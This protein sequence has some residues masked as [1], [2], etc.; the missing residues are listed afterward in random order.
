MERLTDDEFPKVSHQLQSPNLFVNPSF[1]YIEYNKDAMLSSVNEKKNDRWI[2]TNENHIIEFDSAIKTK[3]GYMIRGS[4]LK[5]KE[6]FFKKPFFS[7]YINIFLSDER[8]NEPSL[9][10]VN[11]IKAK[12]FCIQYKDKKVFIPLL[13]SL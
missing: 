10:H 9:Y 4:S 1:R 3:N 5:N 13:H 2:L 8:K 6:D 11:T 7:R 12:L